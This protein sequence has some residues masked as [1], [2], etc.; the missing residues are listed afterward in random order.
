MVSDEHLKRIRPKIETAW[1]VRV[2]YQAAHAHLSFGEMLHFGD[3]AFASVPTSKR[4]S[5]ENDNHRF[6]SVLRQIFRTEYGLILPDILGGVCENTEKVLC[7]GYRDL[8]LRQFQQLSPIT[9]ESSHQKKAKKE[10]Y[11]SE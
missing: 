9:T 11:R 2:I 6:P 5:I 7:V 4:L 10:Y 3:K 1:T 8:P